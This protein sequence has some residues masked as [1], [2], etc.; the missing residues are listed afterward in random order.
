MGDCCHSG[1][2]RLFSGSL[3]VLM[4]LSEIYVKNQRAILILSL[5][6]GPLKR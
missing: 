4:N 3:R 5:S 6:L 2:R 1:N